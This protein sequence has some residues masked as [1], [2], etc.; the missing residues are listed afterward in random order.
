MIARTLEKAIKTKL[1]D[2]KAIILIGPRQTG[3]TTLIKK[4]L[5]AY[6]NESLIL[7]GDDPITQSILTRPSLQQLKQII[8]RNKIVF[9]DEAQ[10]IHEI[11]LTAKIMVDQLP[12][13]QVILSG[14][15]AFELANHTSEPLTGRKWTYNLWP[16]SWQE[17]QD[18]VG[19]VKAEQDLEN[20]LVF[21][22][23]PDVLNHPHEA[24]IVLKELTES[25]L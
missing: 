21:G 5:E 13:V 3:K 14:S 22:F 19:Y 8:G 24:E 25:Y 23:Y 15:S 6:R 17:W 11:G 18:N 10:R 12:E 16:V 2:G 20:R 4:I 1:F 9:I 7:D